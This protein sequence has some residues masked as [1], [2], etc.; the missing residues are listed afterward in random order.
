MITRI[1]TGRDRR[2]CDELLKAGATEAFSET[3]EAS[4]QMGGIVL[5]DMG[6]AENDAAT[7]VETF[8][9]EYFS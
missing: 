3:L 4:L 5:N 1:G 6:V 2:H 8:R 9:R 7:L